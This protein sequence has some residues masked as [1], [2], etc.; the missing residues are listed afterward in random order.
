M[1]N[2]KTIFLLIL[3]CCG[4]LVS[5]AG[6]KTAPTSTGP[7]TEEIAKS[8]PDWC[9]E[10]PED[11]NFFF[12]CASATSR[13]MQLAREK[14]TESAMASIAL[15][16]ESM[17]NTYR[18][19]FQEEV[20]SAVE[21]AYYEKMTKV[22]ERVASITTQDARM[23]NSAILAEDGIWRAYVLYRLPKAPSLK[24]FDDQISQDEEDATRWRESEA[25]E[26]MYDLI[27]RGENAP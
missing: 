22:V 1:N 19:M 20:G 5:C 21:S 23:E 12:Q 26:R 17:L 14:A 9:L 3:L 7:A 24:M 27:E 13:D 2:S 4:F 18:G 16:V 8:I 10:L 6:P 11:P 25:R 15:D